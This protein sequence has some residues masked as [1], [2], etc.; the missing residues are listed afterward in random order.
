MCSLAFGDSGGGFRKRGRSVI[1][2]TDEGFSHQSIERSAAAARDQSADRQT[3]P[4]STSSDV[5]MALRRRAQRRRRAHDFAGAH[6]D[7]A[8]GESDRRLLGALAASAK[9]RNPEEAAARVFL[10][11][12]EP[13]H[14]AEDDVV[15]AGLACDLANCVERQPAALIGFRQH[16]TIE[17][18]ETAQSDEAAREQIRHRLAEVRRRHPARA[19]GIKR[20]DS[21]RR[22]RR[23]LDQRRRLRP[24]LVLRRD[25]TRERVVRSAIDLNYFE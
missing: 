25:R 24:R 23:R 11:V 20:R 12:A 8:N 10:L 1:D 18:T 4:Q 2:S 21:D 6:I 3:M 17:D 7:H 19:I 9:E 14:S 22:P 13:R 16:S 15:D 5:E